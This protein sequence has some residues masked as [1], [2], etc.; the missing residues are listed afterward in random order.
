M[1]IVLPDYERVTQGAGAIASY[2]EQIDRVQ[3][4]F[5]PLEDTQ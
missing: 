5:E 1:Q 3:A 4:E 2:Y